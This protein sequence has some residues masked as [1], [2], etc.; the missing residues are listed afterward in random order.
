MRISDWSSDVCS[1]DLPARAPGGRSR[2]DPGLAAPASFEPDAPSSAAPHREAQ[3]DDAEFLRKP[4]RRGVPAPPQA[5]VNIRY[6]RYP[7]A[8]RGHGDRAALTSA[9]AT[10]HHAHTEPPVPAR[11]TAKAPPEPTK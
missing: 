4:S 10:A 8:D 6:R 5:A 1:S 2:R 3:D 11:T 7:P 9:T